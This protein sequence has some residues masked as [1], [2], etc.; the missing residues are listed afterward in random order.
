[1]SPVVEFINSL[2]ESGSVGSASSKAESIER[3]EEQGEGS[4]APQLRPKNKSEYK[5]GQI[6]VVAD[7][8]WTPSKVQSLE[9]PYVRLIEYFT[10][11]TMVGK[12]ITN[13]MGLVGDTAK[14]ITTGSNATGRTLEPYDTIFDKSDPTDFSYWFPYFNKTSFELNTPNWQ[15]IDG[16]GEAIKTGS[17]IFGSDIASAVGA[18]VNFAK[19]AAGAALAWQ[20]AGVGIFDRPRL[21]A[22]HSERQITISFP[23]YNTLQANDWKKNRDL[24]YLIMHQNHY[25]KRD[26]ITGVPPV[27]YDVYI[28]GQ[29]YCYAAAMTDIKVENLGNVRMIENEDIVPDAYQITLTLSEMTMPSKNQFHALRNGEARSFVNSKEVL[30]SGKARADMDKEKNAQIETTRNKNIKA[31]S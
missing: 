26:M 28:P 11:E 5:S 23:L 18:G 7:F 29:Y 20:Y 31:N 6:N 15:K 17:Q 1:M 8:P 24:I 14:A 19:A 10:N 4:L 30:A 2:A 21:F 16:V 3:F 22:G 13:F 9:I 27:F 25:N 12:S